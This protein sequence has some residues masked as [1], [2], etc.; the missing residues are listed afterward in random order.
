MTANAMIRPFRP[1][2][3][4]QVIDLW[5]RCKL[6]TPKNHSERDIEAN[7]RCSRSYCSSRAMA[8]A[9]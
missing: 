8:G 9:S 2:D 4:E 6:V 5:R 1:A 3:E 7:S